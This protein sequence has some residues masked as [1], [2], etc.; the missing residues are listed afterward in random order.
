MKKSTIFYLIPTLGLAVSAVAVVLSIVAGLGTRN[1]WWIFR[2]GLSLISTSAWIAL[3]G[4]AL[5]LIGGIVVLLVNK[6]KG[7]LFGVL[8]LL[9]GLVFAAG[10]LSMLR[11]A[12]RVPPIHDITTDTVNPPQ[13]V[14]AMSLRGKDA[15]TTTYE[16]WHLAPIQ[17]KAYPDIK[18]LVLSIPAEKAFDHALAVA[19]DMGWSI[20]EANREQKRIEAVATTFWMGFKDDVV[21]RVTDTETGS[22]VDI[23][24]CSRVGRSDLGANARRIRKFLDKMNALGT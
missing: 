13:F 16:S 10:P 22:Q 3:A 15:N 17:K 21:I 12:K 2:T 14:A 9:I 1:E 5:S 7:L 20:T 18:P 8:G 19:D 6:R 24:S 23:R 11:L 4:A